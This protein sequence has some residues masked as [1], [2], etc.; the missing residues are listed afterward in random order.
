MRFENESI[1]QMR[2]ESGCCLTRKEEVG[3]K[4][5]RKLM[6]GIRGMTCINDLLSLVCVCKVEMRRRM[7]AEGKIVLYTN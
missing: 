3:I 1:I 5:I 2:E 4:L 7:V 6:N